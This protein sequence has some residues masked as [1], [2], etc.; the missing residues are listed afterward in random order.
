MGKIIPM[1]GQR[2]AFLDGLKHSTRITSDQP[3][4]NMQTM[5][6]RK[7]VRPVVV[8]FGSD[9]GSDPIDLG[10]YEGV[11]E[12]D[13]RW[14]PIALW[15]TPEVQ[16]RMVADLT[17]IA[18]AHNYDQCRR[19]ARDIAN[20]DT[21]GDGGLVFVGGLFKSM[22]TCPVWWSFKWQ[23]EVEAETNKVKIVAPPRVEPTHKLRPTE[24]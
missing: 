1:D 9:D 12:A 23:W 22:R 8:M 7:E 4:G 18:D 20:V 2:M 13:G 19:F 21:I 11:A 6:I 15:V 5:L 14:G 24:Q 3:E 10:P 16:R 17:A